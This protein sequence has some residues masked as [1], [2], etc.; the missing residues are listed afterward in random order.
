MKLAIYTQQL[1]NYGAHDWSG[2]GECPEYWKAKGGNVFVVENITPRQAAK[3]RAK[4]IPTLTK[5]L[6]YDNKYFR[7]YIVDYR[8]VDDAATIC[9][10]WE[11]PTVLSYE[12]DA[13]VARQ[14][15]VNDG[16]M[17]R[18]IVS[19]HVEYRLGDEDSY[20]V[21]YTLTDGHRVNYKD[22]ARELE[23]RA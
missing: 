7:E 20:C 9:D 6:S 5:L 17:V 13:W 18:I 4:G 2:E 16:N 1:E 11:K 8:I 23:A 15:T 21:E 10:E 19:K 14:T 12:Q 22:L 3:I